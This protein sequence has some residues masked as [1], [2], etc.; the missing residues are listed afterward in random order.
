MLGFTAITAL[1]VLPLSVSPVITYEI[2][3]ILISHAVYDAHAYYACTTHVCTVTAKIAT[4]TMKTLLLQYT[5][6]CTHIQ[7]RDAH[8]HT[9]VH[10][11]LTQSPSFEKCFENLKSSIPSPSIQH[12]V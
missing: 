11:P 4:Y 9:H 10:T 6:A 12:V 5:D 2:L 8:A 1:L 7:T 3:K